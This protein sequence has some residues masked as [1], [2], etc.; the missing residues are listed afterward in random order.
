MATIDVPCAQ[1][2]PRNVLILYSDDHSHHAL[3]AAG[4]KEVMTPNLDRL[5]YRGMLFTQ[6]H[7]MGGHQGAVCVPSRA[8]LL[9]GRYVNRLPGD[10]ATIP[11]AFQSLPEVLRER[12]YTTYHTGKWHS[13]KASHHRMFSAAGDVFFGGMHFPRD[14][15]QEHPTV[16][17][18]DPA[19]VWPETL[20]RRADTFSSALYAD[21]AIRFLS[22][23]EARERPF[24]C[25]VAFT[26]PH[27]PRTPPARWA[28]RYDPA[29]IPLPGNFLP[30]HPFDNGDLNTRDEQLLPRPLDADTMRK[31]IAAYY[32]MISEMDEQVGRILDALRSNGLDRNT[33]VVFAGDNG[34]AMGRHG[35]LGKQ[36][37]YEH[38]IR[39]PMVMAGPGIP[40][41][42]RY[43]GFV[44]LS[45]IAPTL[46]ELLGMPRPESF[47]ALS[48]ASVLRRPDKPLRDRI[49]N[50]YGNWSRSIKTAYGMKLILYNVDG[51][52]REQ[53][54]DLAA[55]PL[56][57]RDLSA[58]PSYRERKAQLR[59]LLRQEMRDKH[60]DLDIDAADWGRAA[61]R[62]KGRGS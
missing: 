6:A 45:D 22:T 52:I 53:L 26:S 49:Y 16:Y 10:G 7:V 56:E 4:N 42:G 21:N 33:L 19:G 62:R 61:A 59:A 35:L 18:F 60:D 54:F 38:S 8:M 17:A 27:D 32:A 2:G 31:D 11:A 25:Y 43:E 14:G 48:H 23:P 39:V 30:R 41:G 3:G 5:A 12:G 34:L 37:L 1:T 24:L 20:R 57:M 28:A 15:G 36:N 29:R 51:Q 55:D 58:D 50:V 9:T 13:D 40:R 44:Y 47:E 46:L